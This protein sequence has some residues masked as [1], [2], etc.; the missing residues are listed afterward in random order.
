MAAGLIVLLVPYGYFDGL[1]GLFDE[2]YEYYTL[3]ICIW[4]RSAGSR[5]GHSNLNLSIIV[6]SCLFALFL[7]ISFCIIVIVNVKD[8]A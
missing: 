1:I 4:L 8:Q 5:H 2:D 6:F 3:G 7:F